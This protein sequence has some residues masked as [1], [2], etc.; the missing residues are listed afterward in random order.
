MQANAGLLIDLSKHPLTTRWQFS[1]ILSPRV[2]RKERLDLADTPHC[3][4]TIPGLPQRRQLTL[5][6]P[7]EKS[8]Y[9]HNALSGGSYK[10][11]RSS[12]Y[13]QQ[14]KL[15]AM[16]DWGGEI[17]GTGSWV[18]DGWIYIKDAIKW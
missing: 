16:R 10:L 13:I 11:T 6:N 12:Y 4:P 7:L 8:N 1:V 3:F 9:P 14:V 2:A 18:E 17:F 15:K 5:R